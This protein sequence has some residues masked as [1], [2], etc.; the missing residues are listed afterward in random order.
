MF[1]HCTFHVPKNK[2]DYYR[3][4]DCM[5][6]VCKDLKKYLFANVFGKFTNKSIEIYEPDPTHLY[7]HLDCHEKLVFK[8][9]EVEF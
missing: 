7:Q 2:H 4:K 6:N 9:T 8:K 3:G 1:T 5:K